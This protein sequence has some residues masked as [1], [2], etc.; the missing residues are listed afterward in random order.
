MLSSVPQL[1]EVQLAMHP[2]ILVPLEDSTQTKRVLPYVTTLVAGGL[3]HLVLLQSIAHPD[4]RF[5]AESFLGRIAEGIARQSVA[6]E[7]C[8]EEGDAGRVIVEVAG[9]KR[10]DLIALA[11]DRWTDLDRWLNGSVADW[12][13]RHTSVPVFLVPPLCEQHWASGH[14]LPVL[15]PLD[16]SSFAEEV[17][18]PATGV[19][20]LIN[21]ELILVRAVDDD[22]TSFVAAQAYL[23]EVAARLSSRG[24][25]STSHVVVGDPV[26]AIAHPGE[27]A[28]GGMIAMATHGRTGLARLILGSVATRILLRAT[29]PLLLVRPAELR[30]QPPE[31]DKRAVEPPHVHISS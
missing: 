12:V 10:A 9:R 17:L 24:I 18:E 4:L 19:A 16:G 5:H 7:T 1:L 29:V 28:N 27:D 23:D 15:V 6:V 21:S 11:T 3:G 20:Q 30:I 13:L 14:S 2:T 8:V 31:P 22:Q 26:W 25:R